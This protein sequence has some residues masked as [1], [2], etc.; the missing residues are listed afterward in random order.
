[1]M[2]RGLGAAVRDDGG[3]AGEGRVVGAPKFHFLYVY[4]GEPEGALH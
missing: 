1:M 4:W 3:V 2:S